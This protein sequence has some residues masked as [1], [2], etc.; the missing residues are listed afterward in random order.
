MKKSISVTLLAII[1]L[2]SC[3]VYQSS[4]VS[5]NDALNEGKAKV[6]KKDNTILIVKDITKLEGTYYMINKGWK[7]PLE[8]SDVE[9]IYL[10]NHPMSFVLTVLSIGI[11]LAALIIYSNKCFF[12][13]P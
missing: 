12:G 8:P 2:Q 5:L 6:I 1:L 4:S 9:Y 3:V 11:P 10:M 13:C 7:I